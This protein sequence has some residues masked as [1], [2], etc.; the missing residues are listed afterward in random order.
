MSLS[1]LNIYTIHLNYYY[2]HYNSDYTIY[3]SIQKIYVSNTI[4]ILLAD[5]RW[6]YGPSEM[7]QLFLQ[8][9]IG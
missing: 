6:S 8:Y 9:W 1:N 4:C 7:V 5:A 3:I 2:S